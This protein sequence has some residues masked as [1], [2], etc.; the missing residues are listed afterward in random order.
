MLEVA[1]AESYARQLRPELEGAAAAFASSPPLQ[2]ALLHPALGAERKR[3]LVA[4]VFA[5][6]SPLLLRALDLVAARGRLALLP[7]IADE[8]ALALL[9]SEQIEAAELVTAAPIDAAQ[10]A[11]VEAALRKAIGRGVELKTSVDP[12]LLGG[13]LVRIA[14]RHYDGSVRG[15]LE[16]LKRRLLA[17]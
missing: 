5:G 15:R 8:Y 12:S 2:R 4:A 16:E 1:Q 11:A 7:A 14:G 6:G 9:R 13:A 17:A 10:V 3:A